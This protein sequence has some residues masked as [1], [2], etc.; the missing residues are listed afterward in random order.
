MSSQIL[1]EENLMK[2]SNGIDDEIELRIKSRRAVLPEVDMSDEDM[3]YA[4]DN[5][6]AM[7]WGWEDE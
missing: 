6:R 5:E 7:Q 4:E 1:H 2:Y 3:L